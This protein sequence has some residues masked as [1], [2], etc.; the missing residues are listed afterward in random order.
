[1]QLNKNQEFFLAFL[2]FTLFLIA[3]SLSVLIATK[4]FF[5]SIDNEIVYSGDPTLSPVTTLEPYTT[6]NYTGPTIS[7]GRRIAKIINYSFA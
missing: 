6:K 2:R 3:I 7:A 5:T 1:M 4:L